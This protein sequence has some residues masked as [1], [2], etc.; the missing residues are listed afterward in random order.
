[1]R[2]YETLRVNMGMEIWS[3]KSLGHDAVEVV[4]CLV[5]TWMTSARLILL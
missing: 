4:V 3:A 2:W 1:M 5:A